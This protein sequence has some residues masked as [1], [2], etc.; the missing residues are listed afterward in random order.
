MEKPV[1]DAAVRAE[2]KAGPGVGGK[3]VEGP[4]GGKKR[5]SEVDGAGAAGG[6]GKTKKR[7]LGKVAA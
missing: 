7:K 6:A 2:M 3:K 4:G 1:V 5:A